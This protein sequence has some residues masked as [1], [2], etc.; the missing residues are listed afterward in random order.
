MIFEKTNYCEIASNF[1]SELCRLHDV[2]CYQITICRLY[3]KT[4]KLFNGV[5]WHCADIVKYNNE[6]YL[7]D[8]T[9]CQFFFKFKNNLDGLDVTYNRTLNFKYTT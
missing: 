2:E 9:F 7:I 5:R 8:L 6:Y 1:V 3:N 4:A